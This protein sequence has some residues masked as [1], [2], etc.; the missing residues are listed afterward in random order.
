MPENGTP[1]G[2]TLVERLIAAREAAGL[3][4]AD[5][6]RVL[7]VKPPQLSKWE[8]GRNVPGTVA[9]RRLAAAY[10]ISVAELTGDLPAA[11]TNE[12]A[13]VWHGEM[14]ATLRTLSG[15]RKALE[16]LA[17]MTEAAETSVRGL[18]QSGVLLAATP[19]AVPDVRP[20]PIEVYNA[21]P[22]E[23]KAQLRAENLREQ[24]EQAARR[25]KR[26]AGGE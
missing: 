25:Q 23:V 2:T 15:M 20:N 12:P 10:G 18:V 17:E 19:S 26:A 11:G 5:A 3:S 16:G 6:A 7:G 1:N 24:A 9:L 8:T 22:D 4:Q 13:A 14:R 21:L